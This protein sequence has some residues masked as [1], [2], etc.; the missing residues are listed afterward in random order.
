[1]SSFDN[2]QSSL[3]ALGLKFLEACVNL[4]AIYDGLGRSQSK[5]KTSSWKLLLGF[6]S[7]FAF[8]KDLLQT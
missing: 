1:M 3:S 5:K 8:M 7:N 4:E 2:S 6:F